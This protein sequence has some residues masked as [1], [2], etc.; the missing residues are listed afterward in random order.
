MYRKLLCFLGYHSWIHVFS[1]YYSAPQFRYCSHCRRCERN[2]YSFIEEWWRI[3]DIKDMSRIE[4][5]E[6]MYNNS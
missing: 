6:K 5:L 2:R 4:Q 1:P 3:E